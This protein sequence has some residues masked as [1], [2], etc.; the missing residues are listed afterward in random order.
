MQTDRDV[1][2]GEVVKD[3]GGGGAVDFEEGDVLVVAGVV[4]EADHQVL[5]GA[6]GAQADG[7]VELVGGEVGGI[8][9]R[10]HLHP[11]LSQGA[12]GPEIDHHRVERNARV[13]HRGDGRRGAGGRVVEVERVGGTV[14]GTAVA[15]HHTVGVGGQ[16]APAGDEVGA[17]V[18]D[19]LVEVVEVGQLRDGAALRAEVDGIAPKTDVAVAADRADAHVVP[20]VGVQSEKRLRGAARL[21]VV[22]PCGVDGGPVLNLPGALGTGGDP[23]EVRAVVREVRD[24]QRVRTDAGAL[25]AED[26]THVAY[27]AGNGAG[28][29]RTEGI[30]RGSITIRIARHVV[31]AGVVVRVEFVGAVGV[32]A[33][34][35]E[36]GDQQVVVAVVGEALVERDLQPVVGARVVEVHIAGID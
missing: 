13:E 25:V 30:V 36:H 7:V 17:V 14:R 29:I 32:G 3:V 31:R 9:H 11:A 22:V 1:V 35:V 8:T 12:V 10:A 27:I 19:H 6:G 23:A 4:L 18:G 34:M 2:D 16:T 20:R 28:D 15:A 24:R 5:P 33:G 26:E 21:A